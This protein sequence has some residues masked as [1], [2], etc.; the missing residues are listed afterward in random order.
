MGQTITNVEILERVKLDRPIGERNRRDTWKWNDSSSRDRTISWWAIF[1]IYLYGTIPSIMRN[2]EAPTCA[3]YLWLYP[4][5]THFR[6]PFTWKL[7]TTTS[8]IRQVK[9][10]FESGYSKYFSVCEYVNSYLVYVI[11]KWLVVIM[12]GSLKIVIP[13][14]PSVDVREAINIPLIVANQSRR[15]TNKV[16]SWKVKEITLLIFARLA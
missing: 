14:L 8:T 1:Y 13:S 10:E 12:S 7:F 16:C 11:W 15:S 4:S 3:R 9:N 6:I 5:H 2:T